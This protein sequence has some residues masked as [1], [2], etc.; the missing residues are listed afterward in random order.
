MNRS[1]LSYVLYVGYCSLLQARSAVLT[2]LVMNA[3]FPVYMELFIGIIYEG[4]PYTRYD[5]VSDIGSNIGA[6][7][8]YFHVLGEK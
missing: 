7:K 6:Q 5:T 1:S 2:I 4:H 3:F 8:E